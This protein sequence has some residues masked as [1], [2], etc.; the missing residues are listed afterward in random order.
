MITIKYI[1]SYL[2]LPIKESDNEERCVIQPGSWVHQLRMIATFTRRWVV[3]TMSTCFILLLICHWRWIWWRRNPT[4]EKAQW[5]RLIP[6]IRGGKEFV[7]RTSRI[8]QS[9]ERI[10][11]YPA[12]VRKETCK[13]QITQ[14]SYIRNIIITL[15]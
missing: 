5:R 2:V 13:C 3:D 1:I 15:L 12:F 4:V 7:D 9:T 6:I 8:H 11:T 10:H 14:Y